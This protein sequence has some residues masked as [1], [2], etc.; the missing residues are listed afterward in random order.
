MSRDAVLPTWWCFQRGETVDISVCARKVAQRPQRG[1]SN[2]G[3]V[4]LLKSKTIGGIIACRERTGS[5]GMVLLAVGRACARML[6]YPSV[7]GPAR[8]CNR[9]S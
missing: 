1:W 2:Q 9:G 8:L 4:L 3:G 6:L 7:Q 5:L